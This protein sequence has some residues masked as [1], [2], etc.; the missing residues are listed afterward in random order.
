MGNHKI[1]NQREKLHK[2]HFTVMNLFPAKKRN[3]NER[4]KKRAPRPVAARGSQRSTRRS[5]GESA[6]PAARDAETELEEVDEK[7][8]NLE[9]RL[10]RIEQVLT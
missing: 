6:S 3:A 5:G 7:I 10:H 9:A 2:R 4:H 1:S 8:A